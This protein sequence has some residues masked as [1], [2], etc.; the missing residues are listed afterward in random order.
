VSSTD[1][2]AAPLAPAVVIRPADAPALAPPPGAAAR[3]APLLDSVGDIPGLA[4]RRRRGDGGQVPAADVDLIDALPR[5]GPAAAWPTVAAWLQAARTATTRRAR[6]ADLAAW[7][8]WL[9]AAAPG[10]TL[11]TATEDAVAAYRDQ[12]ATGTGP[13]ARLVRG[14]RPLSPATVARRLSSLSSLYD[15]AVR[16]RVLAASPAAHVERPEVSGVGRTPARPLADAAA[17]LAGAEAIAD[18]HPADAAAVALALSTGMRAA[19]LE[20]L[21]AGQI[22]A[23]SGHCVARVRVKG[24]RTVAVPLPPRVCALL[25]PLIQGRA[26]HEPVLHDGRPFDRWRMRTALRRAARAA[27]VDPAGLTPHVL[28]ATAI[29]LLLDAGVPVEDVQAMVGHASP[30]TTQRYDRGTRRLDGHPAYRLASIL[31]GGT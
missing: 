24:G 31:A 23:E 5:T 27:G 19:E 10:L 15:Y 12:I 21:T 1:T 3:P 9:A 30:V 22:S 6:L 13:A 2:P 28:R 29:T 14:G 17:L 16:R 25:D 8:R 26:A 18:R 11:W 7:L 20:A 4:P